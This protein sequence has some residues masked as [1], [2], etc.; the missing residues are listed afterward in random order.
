MVHDAARALGVQVL[1]ISHH[2]VALFDQYAD[3]IYEFKPQADGSVEVEER[4]TRPAVV[5]KARLSQKRSRRTRAA[6]MKM[7][8]N[9]IFA[10]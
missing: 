6:H 9:F 1:M 4:M 7:K 2:D 5:P 3:K 8:S 10:A